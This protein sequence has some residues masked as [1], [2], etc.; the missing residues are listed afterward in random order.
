MLLFPLLPTS[1]EHHWTYSDMN[2]YFFQKPEFVSI[3]M[4]YILTADFVTAEQRAEDTL[5]AESILSCW[6]EGIEQT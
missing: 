3:L 2:G 6:E 5:L 1:S 4:R